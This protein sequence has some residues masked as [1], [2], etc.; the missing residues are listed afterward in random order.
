MKRVALLL[1]LAACPKHGDKPKAQTGSG[2]GSA[3]PPADAAP[4]VIKPLP[5]VPFGLPAMPPNP[6][7]TPEAVARDGVRPLGRHGLHA[8]GHRRGRRLLVHHDRV[9]LAAVRD[10]LG[11]RSLQ[12]GAGQGGL[13]QV[14]HVGVVIGGAAEHHAIDMAQVRGRRLHGRD[15]AI[16]HH[17][18]PRPLALEAVGPVV[19]QRR[20]FAVLLRRQALQPGIAGVHHHHR[21]AG[22][23]HLVDEAGEG[24]VV[25]VLVHAEAALHRDRDGGCRGHRRHAVGHQR[26]LSHQAGAEAAHLHA[27]GRAAAVEVDLGIAPLAGDA[28]GLRQQRRLAATQLQ[29][30]RL[31]GRVEAEQALAI[32]VDHRVGVD[33]LGIQPRRRRQQPVE[34]P[35]MAVGLVHHRGDGQAQ[36]GGVA[37]GGAIRLILDGFFDCH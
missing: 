3:A 26:R 21:A 23:D 12:R 7:V 8:V 33:H 2:S 32:A 5:A 30:E 22:G 24:I 10:G 19:A 17:R 20:D 16:D 31:L 29:G 4:L 35:A 13:E 37:L 1:V 14:Q 25:V 9:H 15:A 27:I 36:G 28:R 34:E 18:Q 11:D 6:R